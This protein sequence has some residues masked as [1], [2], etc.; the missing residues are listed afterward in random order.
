MKKLLLILPLLA[1][2]STIWG[3]PE[4][5]IIYDCAVKYDVMVDRENPL[6]VWDK[7][8]LTYR[9]DL[10]QDQMP[11]SGPCKDK[12]ACGNW[13]TGTVSVVRGFDSE[14]VV[15]HE[16]CHA[17]FMHTYHSSFD[18]TRMYADAAAGRSSKDWLK[19]RTRRQTMSGKHQ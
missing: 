1:S 10:E 11:Q 4:S 14:Y 16:I 12:S 13:L 6:Q 17:M 5:Q 18:A 8:D 3:P 15:N 7:E 9:F 19:W 2:C